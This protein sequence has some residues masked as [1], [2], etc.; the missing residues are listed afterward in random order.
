MSQVVQQ[1]PAVQAQ[2]VDTKTGVVTQV[3]LHLLQAI[4]KRTGSA[5]G[6]SDVPTGTVAEFAGLAAPSGWSLCD[7]EEL[8]RTEQSALYAA[9]GTKWGA[10]NGTTTF[11]KPDFLNKFRRGGETAG[12]VGGSDTAKLTEVT[13]PAHTHDF[14]GTAHSHPLVD[15]G[16]FHFNSDTSI[17]VLAGSG[18]VISSGLADGATSTDVTGATVGDATVAGTIGE[19]GEGQEF[20]I[21]PAY[22]TTLPIIKL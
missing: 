10:G 16:H 3:W 20:S 21:V 9:I 22:V 15:P 8:S 1:F 11:N 2:M 5:T 12:V 17:S 19:T 14:A 7:G 6:V 4:W 13:L 18:A